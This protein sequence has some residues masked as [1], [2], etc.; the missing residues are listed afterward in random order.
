MMQEYLKTKEEYKDCILFYRL[1][2]FYEMFFDDALTASKELELTLTG[3]N[4]GLEERAPM[5]GVP[6]HA[7]DTY[8]SRL[9]RN[10]HKV[11]ICEQLEDPKQAKGLVKRG[12]IRIVTPGT[13]L[14]ASDNEGSNNYIAC[15]YY[16]DQRSIGLAFADVSTGDFYTTQTDSISKVSDE[17]SKYDPSEFIYNS[18]LTKEESD[19]IKDQTDKKKMCSEA[20]RS[21]FLMDNATDV[22][23]RH[24]KVYSTAALGLDGYPEALIASGALTSYLLDTQMNDLSHMNEIHPYSIGRYLIIDHSTYRN[25]ELTETMREKEKRGSLFWVLDRTKTA[26]GQRKLKNLIE[27]PLLDV[28]EIEERLDAIEEMNSNMVDRE[29]IREYLS[30]V[31]DLLRLLMRFS[32]KS[33]NPRDL[34]A[35]RDSI[36]PLGPIK[37]LLNG[38]HSQ[39]LHEI[40]DQ[41]DPMDDL[42]DLLVAA[43]DEDAPASVHDAGILKEGFDEEADRLR[44]AKTEGKQW[45][46]D[47]ET[48]E[49]ERTGIPKL[50]VRYN[51]VFGYFIEV[52]NSYRDKVPDDYIRKQTLVNGERYYTPELKELENTI[53]G[54]QD[55]LNS[56]EHEIFDQILEKL[57]EASVRI[58]KTADAVSML[59]VLAGVS[60]VSQKNHY[61]R[62]SINDQ[63]VI[64]IRGGRHPVV[65]KM[66]PDG[67]F[68]ANDTYLDDEDFRTAII[69][70]PNMAGKS[71]YMRQTALI[72]L[73]AQCGFFVPADSADIG[74][75]DRI[76]TRV[77]ASDDLASG[78]STFM[79]EMNEVANIL[80]NATSKSL[81]ILDE[82]GRGTSTFD[83]LSIAQAVVEYVSDKNKIG[84]KTLFATHYHELTSLEGK[85]DGVH[86]YCVAVKEEG[87]DVTF[88][89]KIV[90]GEADRSYGIEVAKLAGVPQPVLRRA[91]R[92]ADKLEREDF[93]NK[94]RSHRKDDNIEGQMSFFDTMV[95][96]APRDDRAEKLV[97]ELKG[98]DVN[99]MTPMEALNRLS[100][101]VLESKNIK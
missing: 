53:L 88:L 17:V 50:K 99:N 69:T 37:T 43:I 3:K 52:S 41:I 9:V 67:S 23:T 95:A 47:L 18:A 36:K 4:C 8:I 70:G 48:R 68:I 46:S 33:A 62:P 81:V 85:L 34:L 21:Y 24:F 42:Y 7:V 79:V 82:I 29:E 31:Y 98:I 100:E 94:S 54:A 40:S 83:G 87:K 57:N 75:C 96:D 84:A 38:F 80:K 65:E 64:D 14:S 44:R 19:F 5:C 60:D 59:D 76:F 78:Q 55:K 90:P 93:E 92:I 30:G 13:D 11:A 97:N 6:F 72:V 26:M 101:L 35:F 22:L 56:L 63:G 12:V 39:L 86:N 73:M 32:Y 16:K 25:L 61:V 15:I 71:T 77:G 28:S 27:H 74:I 10:G 49:R 58:Q 2:D 51:K 66:I 91:K 1:G 89:R 20:D 45:L